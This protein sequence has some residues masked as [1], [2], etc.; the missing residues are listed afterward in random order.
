MAAGG[1]TQRR[2]CAGCGS[3]SEL[4]CVEIR[5]GRGIRGLGS[6]RHR[7]TRLTLGGYRRDIRWNLWN[8]SIWTSLIAVVAQRE[9]LRLVGVW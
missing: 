6:S 4:A 9:H 5:Q 2:L 1:P 3:V 8:H 7:S